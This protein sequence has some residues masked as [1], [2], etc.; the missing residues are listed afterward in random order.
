[1]LNKV[2][3]EVSLV[4]DEETR[5]IDQNHAG[6]KDPYIPQHPTPPIHSNLTPFLPASPNPDVKNRE[7]TL[8]A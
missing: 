2:F 4:C 1:M 5:S 8:D 3:N 7:K 6:S